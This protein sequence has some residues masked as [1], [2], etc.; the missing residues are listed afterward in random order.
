MSNF[1]RQ[2]LTIVE[3]D[4]PYCTRVFGT[5]PCTAALS[6]DVPYKCFN[7]RGTCAD[8]VN[9]DPAPLT[10]RFAKNQQGLPK[11]QTVFPALKSVSTN[12]TAINLSGVDK[13]SGALGTRARV[14]LAFNGFTYQDTLTDKYQAERISGAAQ[15]D[16]IGYDLPRGG[17]WANQLA[18]NPYY[19][20]NDVRVKNGYVG[21]SIASM[22]TM[23]YVIS[24][25]DGPDTGDN[26][27]IT[28]KDVLDLAE[29]AKAVYPAVTEGKLLAAISAVA[30]TATL[31]PT[32]I[33]ADYAT[34]GRVCIGREIM[35]YTRAGDVLTFTERGVDGT[36]VA[37]HTIN[38]SVQQCAYFNG[39]RICDTIETIL[40]DGEEGL[41][42]SYINTSEWR[43]EEDSWFG[44]LRVTRTIPKPVGKLTLVAELCQLGVMIWPKEGEKKIEFRAIRPRAPGEVI[45]RIT[46]D[47]NLIEGR[48][49]AK[50]NDA[51]RISALYFHHGLKDPTDSTTDV[52]NYDKHDVTFVADNPYGQSAIK[53]IY[54]PWFGQYGDSAAASVVAE[55]LVSRYKV[56]PTKITGLLDIKDRGAVAL[57]ALLTVE[58]AAIRQ[59][60]GAIKPQPMQV[61]SIE[62]A[63]DMVAFSAET[64][65]IDGRFGFWMTDPQGSYNTA[66]AD[67]KQWGAFWMDDSIGTFDDGTGPYVYF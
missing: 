11:G 7:T 14:T 36:T 43:A 48:T 28:V 52:K 19:L 6:A 61:N 16:G 12:P 20:G 44:G 9:F 42:S 59:P 5:A 8:P 35:I 10:L 34:S 49:A 60:N 50:P 18:R 55:R 47:A 24:G 29:N 1:G 21:D 57:G 26:V 63:N 46:D 27:T 45:T 25:W 40:Q 58:T 13:D 54:C 65:A 30:M 53:T 51:Q 3:I 31:T 56:T 33:G 2:P 62:V 4:V 32:G 15:F 66:T 67:E 17:F 39:T 41:P 23:H 38:D 37:P 64:Y 22:P